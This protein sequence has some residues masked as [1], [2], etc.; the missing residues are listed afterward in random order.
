MNSEWKEFL[1][2]DFGEILTGTTPNTKRQEYYGG[3]Y[4]F[5]SPADLDNGRYVTTAHKFITNEGLKVCRT[6][7]KHSI[8][9]GCIGNIGKMG[10]TNDEI[11]AFNQQINAIICNNQFIP[12]F[13]YYLILYNKPILEKSSVKT[14]LPI[15]NKGNFQKI[16]LNAPQLSEQCK[17][18]YILSTLQKA[19]EQQDKLIKH[20]TELKKALMQK[21]FT[22][23]TKSEKQKETE[24][25]WVPESWEVVR[26]GTA[27][28]L[29]G[30]FAFKSEE[31]IPDS[32]VQLIRMGN[33]YQNKLALERAPIFYPER[34][35]KDFE[36]YILSEGDL[37][38]S[39]TGTMGKEDYGFT[40]KIPKTTKTLLL[41]QRI[42]KFEII[43]KEIDKDYL[44]Q[45]LLSR[46]FLDKLYKTAKGTKQ[47]NL[48]SNEMKSLLLLKPKLD[49]QLEIANALGNLEQKIIFHEKKKQILSDLF[50][51]LLHELMTGQRR[52]NEIDFEA[53]E[54][55]S[56]YVGT[57]IYSE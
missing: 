19:I 52:V 6:L 13:I 50:K 1:I 48:S 27:V 46:V 41:N 56:R 49:E 11:S 16:K 3:E 26:L 39:L 5:I 42:A 45:Y 44:K 22:E 37:V 25:G 17:I 20:T 47:A 9:I 38:M 4:K 57:E 30:G 55:T 43:D 2:E 34:Y 32:D 10:M 36:N 18:A 12:D 14:T 29:K 40:V 7:P 28:K 8:L 21:L 33:L 23:G 54:A 53:L 31:G 15:L 51:T 24:I 35:K